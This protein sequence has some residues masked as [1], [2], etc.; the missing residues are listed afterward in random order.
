VRRF[1]SHGCVT[2]AG[3]WMFD[4]QLDQLIMFEV[5]FVPS[6]FLSL[7]S[8]IQFGEKL[9]PNF[10]FYFFTGDLF[11]KSGEKLG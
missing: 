8:V 9:R 11:G 1:Y 10:H 6:R 7:L 2:F 4:S 3:F 5:C